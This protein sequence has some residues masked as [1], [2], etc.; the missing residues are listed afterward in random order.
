MRSWTRWSVWLCL[1][2]MLWTTG[3]ESTHRHPSQSKATSCSICVVAHSA[4]PAVSSSH[5]TPVFAA[6]LLLQEEDVITKARFDFSEAGIR[7]P[8]VL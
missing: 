2:L 7:G 8:P 5:A 3:A 1:S 4:S 6:I